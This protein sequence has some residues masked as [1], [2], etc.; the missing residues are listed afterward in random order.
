MCKTFFFLPPSLPRFFLPSFVLVIHETGS[1]CVPLAGLEV[2]DPLASAF[3]LLG[4]TGVHY[5]TSKS[6]DKY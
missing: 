2:R 5:Y 3:Q 1:F 6:L 4:I